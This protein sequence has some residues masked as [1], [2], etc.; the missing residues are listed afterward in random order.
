MPL[1]NHLE[2]VVNWPGFDNLCSQWKNSTNSEAIYRDV[3]DGKIW[4]DFQCYEGKPF[5][6]EPFTYG[7]MLNIDWFQPCKLWRKYWAKNRR[8]FAPI[9]VRS[10]DRSIRSLSIRFVPSIDRF[11]DQC[12]RLST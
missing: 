7:L 3:F 2:I 9:S 10:I 1:Q 5:L 6:G 12:D 4:R 11:V 8:F